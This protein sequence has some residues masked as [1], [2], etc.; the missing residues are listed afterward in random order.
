MLSNT[1]YKQVS[2][3]KIAINLQFNVCLDLYFRNIRAIMLIESN[4]VKDTSMKK[5][6]TANYEFFNMEKRYEK[7]QILMFL[8]LNKKITR[9]NVEI[10]SF[11]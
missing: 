1:S 6:S 2:V 8:I 10:F 5:G 4:L 7:L 11:I 3:L 9:L